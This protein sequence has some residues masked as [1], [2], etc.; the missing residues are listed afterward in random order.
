MYFC[1]QNALWS[2]QYCDMVVY[3]TE[4]AELFLYLPRRLVFTEKRK[5]VHE[6]LVDLIQR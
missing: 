1:D 2:H 3:S 5:G 4:G 6:P